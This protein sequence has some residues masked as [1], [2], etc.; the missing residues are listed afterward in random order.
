MK[1]CMM[2]SSL[3]SGGAERV[4]TTLANDRADK[5]W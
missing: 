1:L 5:G 2:I 4:A 3:S